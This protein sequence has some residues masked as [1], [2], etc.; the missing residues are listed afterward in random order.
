M[1]ISA[2]GFDDWTAADYANLIVFACS[3]DDSREAVNAA[4]EQIFAKYPDAE[5]LQK[6]R[7]LVESESELVFPQ[8]TAEELSKARAPHGT[9]ADDAFVRVV[10][11][12]GVER[13]IRPSAPR[14]R[15]EDL[16]S[17]FARPASEIRFPKTV[18]RGGRTHT[19]GVTAEE[20]ALIHPD[21]IDSVHTK[22]AD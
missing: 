11:I 16:M 10:V 21:H 9:F 3:D 2:N 18:F 13:T 5:T 7:R 4:C 15:R 14:M 1:G 19:V 8:L 12:D 20:R 17:L 6:A 22:S